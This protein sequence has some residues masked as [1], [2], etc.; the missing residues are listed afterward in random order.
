[1][2]VIL[3]PANLQL[4]ELC[5]ESCNS[6][7]QTCR[8]SANWRVHSELW[9]LTL[10]RT[11]PLGSRM[12]LAQLLQ[13]LSQPRV[14]SPHSARPI[15]AAFPSA[16]KASTPSYRCVSGDCWPYKSRSSALPDNET[17][18]AC[19]N[20]PAEPQIPCDPPI[21]SLQCPLTYE[22]AITFTILSPLSVLLSASNLGESTKG[23]R[24][25][26]SGLSDDLPAQS[27][28]SHESYSISN[29]KSISNPELY[30]FE[31]E[32]TVSCSSWHRD[33]P[34]SDS[35]YSL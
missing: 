26:R 5:T 13:S 10:L 2:S 11:S 16:P 25:A 8:F 24:T 7:T 21:S 27:E 32:L 9:S 17:G 29:S 6:D 22:C 35:E 23:W 4:L 15:A 20:L 18:R 33:C 12:C 28:S 30:A 1:M 34:S 14:D 3:G 31:G 19:Y